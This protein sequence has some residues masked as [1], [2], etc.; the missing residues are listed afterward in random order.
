MHAVRVPFINQAHEVN[1][2]VD[3]RTLKVRWF[4]FRWLANYT[5]LCYCPP[6]FLESYNYVWVG[7]MK[8]A[9]FSGSP[10]VKVSGQ[11]V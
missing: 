1:V 10:Y 4:F 3:F 11:G 6:S 2:W 7:Y 8:L 9:H 5:K